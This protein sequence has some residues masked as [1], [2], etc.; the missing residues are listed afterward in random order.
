VDLGSLMEGPAANSARFERR[1]PVCDA[2]VSDAAAATAK[3]ACA[4]L[5]SAAAFASSCKTGP[6]HRDILLAD[7]SNLLERLDDFTRLMMGVTGVSSPWVGF[8]VRLAPGMLCE[9]PPLQLKSTGR[10]FRPISRA[11]SRG[12]SAP[13][14]VVLSIAPARNETG[15][16]FRHTVAGAAI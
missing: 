12:L 7:A 13:A 10:S 8:K 15:Q 4:V 11:R 9:A 2:L 1:N 16:R 6:E 5:D 14:S 3:D